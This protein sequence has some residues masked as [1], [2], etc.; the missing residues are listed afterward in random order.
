MSLPVQAPLCTT[1]IIMITHANVNDARMTSYVAE[2]HYECAHNKNATLCIQS[3]CC[4]R[5][6][7]ATHILS[8]RAGRRLVSRLPPWLACL[9]SVGCIFARAPLCNAIKTYGHITTIHMATNADLIVSTRRATLHGPCEHRHIYI[10]LK[11]KTNV[12]HVH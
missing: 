10:Y 3:S 8:L 1:L 4:V 9:F 7:H 11:Y 5:S 2:Y 6:K 12:V